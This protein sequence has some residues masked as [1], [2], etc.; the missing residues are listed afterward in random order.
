MHGMI[1]LLF[2]TP[3]F[4][5]RR[6]LLPRPENTVRLQLTIGCVKPKEFE[7]SLSLKGIMVDY[8]AKDLLKNK[9]FPVLMHEK[10]FE[11]IIAD[12][13]EMKIRSENPTTREIYNKANTYGWA[14]LHESA[15]V[16]AALKYKEHLIGKDVHFATEQIDSSLGHPHI[17]AIK[18]F[19]K[20]PYLTGVPAHP[21]KRWGPKDKFAFAIRKLSMI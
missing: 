7:K 9:K 14:S 21:D 11:M 6:L 3:E 4:S 17:L 15:P 20:V 5:E 10:D 18:T 2:M 12:V 8:S 19:N 1:D 13:A 16:H